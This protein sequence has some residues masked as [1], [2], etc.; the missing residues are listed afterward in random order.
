LG[1]RSFDLKKDIEINLNDLHTEWKNHSGTRYEYAGEVSHLEKVVK[2]TQEKVK[3]LRSRLLKE[4][5]EAKLTSADLRESYYR[6]HEDHINAKGEQIEAEYELSM[7]WNALKAL[8]DRKNA[9]ENEVRLWS[10]N[11]FSTPVDNS[12][13]ENDVL[14]QIR[15]DTTKR[16]RRKMNK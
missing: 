13:K 9:L 15:D 3:V 6:D 1:E 8:D 12:N 10:S 11:Y 2:K 5:K 7:A 4:A 14:T 16:V